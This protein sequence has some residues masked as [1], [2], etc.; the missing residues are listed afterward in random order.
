MSLLKSA[1]FKTL[2]NK[3]TQQVASVVLDKALKQGKEY[4]DSRNTSSGNDTDELLLGLQ[5]LLAQKPN[6][7]VYSITLSTYRVRV[8]IT[9]GAISH[10]DKI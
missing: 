7:G 5:H 3:S 9:S 6:D 2:K 8:K 1:L 4:L 10:I